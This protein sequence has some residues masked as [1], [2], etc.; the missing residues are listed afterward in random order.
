MKNLIMQIAIAVVPIVFAYFG[1][2]IVKNRQAVSLIQIIQ[3]LAEAAVVAA[4]QLGVTE[5][6]TGVAKKSK[7]VA[8]VQAGL[9]KLGF[10]AV[11]E[12]TVANAVESAYA[13]MKEF[14]ES[15]YTKGA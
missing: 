10:T 14:I 4:E 5:A 2:A 7:A 6:V 15:K 1:N 8:D 9:A 11:D 12:K 3:P 13:S